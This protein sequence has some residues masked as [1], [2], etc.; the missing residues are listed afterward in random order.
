MS[1]TVANQYIKAR[2]AGDNATVLSLVTDDVHFI[3]QRDGEKNGKREFAKY[4]DDVKP[5][6]TW[7]D[8]VLQSDGTVT[9]SGKV[10]LVA[11]ISIPVKSTFE[12]RG[13][14][15]SKISIRRA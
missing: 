9:I 14:L 4:L 1:L 11:F 6:G 7:S 3:S 5:Q 15:I 8:A 13:G 2:L 10:K 12:F